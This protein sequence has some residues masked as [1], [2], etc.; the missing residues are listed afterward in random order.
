MKTA[1]LLVIYDLRDPE[2][3]ERARRDR[4]AWGRKLSEIHRVDDDHVAIEYKSGGA[5]KASA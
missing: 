1:S 3:R 5:L 2:A 4:Q